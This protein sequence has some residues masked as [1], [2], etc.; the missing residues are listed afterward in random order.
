MQK[1][2]AEGRNAHKISYDETAS[3]KICSGSLTPIFRG[4][5]FVRS[6]YSGAFYTAAYKDTVCVIDGMA[7]VGLETVGLVS[8][9]AVTGGAGAGA[10]GAAGR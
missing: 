9:S 3:F 2:A 1:S 5:A 7:Q 10:A 6:P 4:D 8:T